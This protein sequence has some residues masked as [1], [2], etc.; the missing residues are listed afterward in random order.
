MVKL[1]VMVPTKE[2]FDAYWYGYGE[3][4][5]VDESEDGKVTVVVDYGDDQYHADY[6]EGR[7]ASGL[8]F[9]KVTEE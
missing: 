3:V 2:V 8:Y 7:F 4:V 9:A 6:Q 5:S 1:T